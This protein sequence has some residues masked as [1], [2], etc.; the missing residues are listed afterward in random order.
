MSQVGATVV[1]KTLAK[2]VVDRGARIEE[3][4][5][6]NIG[7]D[8]DFLNMVEED[9]LVF[10]L[11]HASFDLNSNYVFVSL[12]NA[13]EIKSKLPLEISPKP[14]SVLRYHF[15]LS[16]VPPDLLISQYPDTPNFS[17][18]PRSNFMILELGAIAQ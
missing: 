2:L 9:R 11:N 4:Y 12:I 3:S 16:S 13:K 6:L 18:I 14:S 7:G 1:H 10:E 15:Y 5:Q 8:T 17:P